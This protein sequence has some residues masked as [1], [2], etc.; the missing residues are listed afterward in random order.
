M[1]KKIKAPKTRQVN[2][3]QAEPPVEKRVR[4]GGM[5]NFLM[6][7]L[8]V[9]PFIYTKYNLDPVVAIRYSLTAGLVLLFVLYFYLVRRSTAD[10]KWPLLIKLIFLLGILY[11]VWNFIGLTQAVN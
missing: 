3:K 5:A 8:L 9:L 1:S 2:T 10:V 6:I 7:F 11:G 4:T